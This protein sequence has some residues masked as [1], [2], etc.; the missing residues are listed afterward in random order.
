MLLLGHETRTN[1]FPEPL[2]IIFQNLFAKRETTSYGV[3]KLSH[4][5]YLVFKLENFRDANSHHLFI[6]YLL[7]IV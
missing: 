1:L 5:Q 7:K 4:I 6:I 2:G 3:S